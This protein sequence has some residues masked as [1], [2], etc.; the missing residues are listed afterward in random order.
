MTTSQERRQHCIR[1]PYLPPNKIGLGEQIPEFFRTFHDSAKTFQT[2]RRNS[3]L[4]RIALFE[5][6]PSS[7]HNPS[8][9][10]SAQPGRAVPWGWRV[11]P[12]TCMQGCLWLTIMASLELADPAS[13]ESPDRWRPYPSVGLLEGVALRIHWFDSTD[14]LREAAKTV[15]KKST[16]SA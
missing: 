12:R 3:G 11:F 7:P 16:R 1:R 14:E 9:A 10:R 6:M 2:R 13:A 5:P 8:F 4:N 15:G